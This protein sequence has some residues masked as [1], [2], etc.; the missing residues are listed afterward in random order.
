MLPGHLE[1]RRVPVAKAR[2]PLL[3]LDMLPP[4]QLPHHCTSC[5]APGPQLK[6]FHF[7]VIR[8]IIQTSQSYPPVGIRGQLPSFS[9]K[10]CLPSSC[11]F[12]LFLSTALAWPYLVCVV[13]LPWAFEYIW[14]KSC[15]QSHLPRVGCHVF[16]YLYSLGRRFPP[17]PTG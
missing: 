9:Y 8:K 16:G 5:A 11:L 12:T 7:S 3:F 6:G 13:L 4:G 14:L 2:I 17:S 1:L 15:C 10:A